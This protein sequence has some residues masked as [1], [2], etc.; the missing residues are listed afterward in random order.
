MQDDNS[1]V[2]SQGN[3][4]HAYDREISYNSNTVVESIHGTI[5]WT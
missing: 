2:K 1:L 4:I 3:L 5:P